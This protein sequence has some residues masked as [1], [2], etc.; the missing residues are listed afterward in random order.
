[1]GS[2]QEWQLPMGEEFLTG[3]EPKDGRI[4]L[5]SEIH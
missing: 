2:V 4:F 1:M 3:E 5:L